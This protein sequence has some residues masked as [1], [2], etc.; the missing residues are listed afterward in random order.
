MDIEECNYKQKLFFSNSA[1]MYEC[2]K[3]STD[4]ELT[5]LV[6]AYTVYGYL[7]HQDFVKNNKSESHSVELIEPRLIEELTTTL[8]VSEK[9]AKEY[10][11]E[12]MKSIKD[13][14]FKGDHIKCWDKYE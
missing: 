9:Q 11:V 4:T 10:T 3:K 13:I 1:K 14:W 2:L 7:L 8:G 5:D 6:T 12:I